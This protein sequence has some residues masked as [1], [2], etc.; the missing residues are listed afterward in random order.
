MCCLPPQP[1]RDSSPI[2]YGT[3]EPF[4]L[5]NGEKLCIMKI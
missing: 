5:D 3:G 1:L 2:P 4:A